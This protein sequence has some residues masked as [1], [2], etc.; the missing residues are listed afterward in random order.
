MMRRRFAS[1][2]FLVTAIFSLA[3]TSASGAQLKQERISKSRHV[4]NDGVQPKEGFVPDETTAILIAVAVL[5]PIYGHDE[6][7][8]QKPFTAELRSGVWVVQGSMEN[9]TGVAE[10]N[11]SKR[12]GTILRVVH[13]K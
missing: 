2:A 12:T 11:I 8:E 3:M 7:E 6:I 4:P 1:C 9:R 13:G 5:G 10:V